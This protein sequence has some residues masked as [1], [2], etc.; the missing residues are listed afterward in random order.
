MITKKVKFLFLEGQTT[1]EE[2]FGSENTFAW[3]IN[4]DFKFSLEKLFSAF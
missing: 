1:A 4:F 2:I 3:R